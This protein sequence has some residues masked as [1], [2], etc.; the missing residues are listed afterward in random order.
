MTL[1]I[2]NVQSSSS[3]DT[4]KNYSSATGSIGVPIQ[5]YTA[6]QFR[7]FSTTIALDTSDALTQVLQNYSFNSSRHYLGLNIQEEPN[8]NFICQTRISISGTN[9]SAELYVANQTGSTVNSPAFTLSLAV[10]RFT[11]PFN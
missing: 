9:L 7:T 5:S 1:D 4:F 6:G 10:R 2:S 3:I 8:A 11:A